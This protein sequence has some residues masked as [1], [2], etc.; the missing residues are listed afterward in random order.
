MKSIYLFTLLLLG[1]SSN[2]FSQIDIDPV[3][4]LPDPCMDTVDLEFYALPVGGYDCYYWFYQDILA[5]YNLLGVYAINVKWDFGDGSTYIQTNT[6]ATGHIFNEPGTY[7]VCA[8]VWSTNGVECCQTTY[9][10][11]VVVTGACDLC[12]QLDNFDFKVSGTGPF[13]VEL[14]CSLPSANVFGY[15]VDYGDGRIYNQSLPFTLVYFDDG[16][17]AFSITI[18][19]FNPAT[20]TCCSRKVTKRVNYVEGKSLE[21]T[22]I[23]DEVIEEAPISSDNISVFPNPTSGEFT[24]QSSNGLTIQSATVYN[25]MGEMLHSEKAIANLSEVQ[26]NLEHLAPG[27]YYVLVNEE[28]EENRAFK[29][30]IIE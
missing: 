25:V 28:D 15:L 4:V 11:D 1:L 8:T 21:V 13:L 30:L 2:S 16:S 7:T 22:D 23:T 17:Y 3:P 20:G 18:F 12:E 10:R 14:W 9:C 27:I 19:Y 26:M 6:S 5:I 29:Q 24:L